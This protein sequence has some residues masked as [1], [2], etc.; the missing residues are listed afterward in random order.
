MNEEVEVVLRALSVARDGLRSFFVKEHSVGVASASS[1]YI[2][3]VA[4]VFDYSSGKGIPSA[5]Q[6]DCNRAGTF[7]KIVIN[8]T[9][10]TN[11]TAKASWAS[12]KKSFIPLFFL[13]ASS[14]GV[15]NTCPFCLE[16]S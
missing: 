14:I 1:F 6:Q 4:V 8:E 7:N 15:I 5:G 3:S 11:V 9:M 12:S 2:A 13:R 10:E 16:G